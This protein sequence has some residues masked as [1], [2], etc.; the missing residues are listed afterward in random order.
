MS[1]D[2]PIQS[3]FAASVNE[4]TGKRPVQFGRTGSFSGSRLMLPCGKCAG[5][6]LERSR[7]WAMR[8]M[9]ENK[10]HQE[11]CFV[12]WTYNNECL[13][14]VG[15]LVPQH[16]QAVHKRLHNR[17]LD[18]RGYGIRYYGAGEYGDKNKRPHYHSLIFGFRP[19]DG[20]YYS[21]NERGE[22]IFDSDFL[23]DVWQYKGA[24]RFG[25]VTFDSA[26]YVARY[27]VK[28]VDGKKRD[29]GHYLVYDAD[30][31]LHERVPEF[32]QMSRRPGI[33]ATYFEKYGHE[34]MAH[35]SVIVNGKEVPSIRYYDLKIEALD[36]ERMR[37][38]KRNRQR[39]AVWLERQVD[40]R[41]IKELLRLKQLNMK[42]RSL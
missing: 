14:H 33:G 19:N 42:V 20:K 29:E 11:S 41:R 30:G 10:M 36:P 4:K 22:P 21:E 2:A 39:K 38:I 31:V 16:L 17:L 23:N 37:V 5:C 3:F 27:C 26:A 7:V 8:L 34:I 15:T 12:T 40:R 6:K 24:A 28:K 13:P 9:H 18:Q 32:A 35:D 1:C 25:D